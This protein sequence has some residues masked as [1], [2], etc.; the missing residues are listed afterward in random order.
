MAS[1]GMAGAMGR[2]MALALLAIGWSGAAGA[3]PLD[4]EACNT[5]EQERAGLITAGANQDLAKGAEWGRAN[6]NQERLARVQRLIE[7]DGQL[8]FRCGQAK[9]AAAPP[10]AKES[11]N[12][13]AAPGAKAPVPAKKAPAAA[14]TAAAQPKAAAPAPKAA[15]KAPPAPK[16]PASAA[17]KTAAPAAKPADPKAARPKPND[18]YV[19]PPKQ[20]QLPWAPP[21]SAQQ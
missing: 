19:P 16:P 15:A 1:A 8:A 20:E 17:P 7:I 9:A 12:K 4:E 21:E 5:L 14:G 2:A 3:A 11:E 10:A 13:T 6:L 18:A